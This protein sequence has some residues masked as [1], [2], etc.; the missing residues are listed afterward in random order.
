M[1]VLLLL[2]ACGVSQLEARTRV[3]PDNPEVWAELGHAYRSAMRYRRAREAYR[4]AIR[5]DS[6]QAALMA[7]LPRDRATIR[8]LRKEVDRHPT[9]D[10][11]WGDLGD[12]LKREGDLPAAREAYLEAF[13]LD[14]RDNEWH[15]ALIELG[16]AEHVIDAMRKTLR[17]GD[18]ESLGDFADLLA[19]A[20][21]EPEACTYWGRAFALDPEDDEWKRHAQP[22]GFAPPPPTA[23]P[24]DAGDIESLEA[25]VQ[26][27]TQLLARLGRAYLAAGDRPR[28]AEH[29][30][31]ALLLDPAQPHTLQAYLAATKRTRRAALEGL[32]RAH[33]DDAEVL[34]TLGAH[35]LDLG[36]HD[37][38]RQ[39]VAEAA[40]QAPEDPRWADLLELLSP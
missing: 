4:Q 34:G 10:E 24:P 22:C 5:L 36:L 7:R 29:L 27:D 6:D 11:R 31:A 2:G 26:H 17:E 38:A 40:A 15:F 12:A 18:D 3:E 20:G 21:R 9:D 14:S 8:R 39:T 37:Q 25:Q 28:A 23:D 19:A 30:W 1:L 33:P 13:R 32:L 16:D 35:Y